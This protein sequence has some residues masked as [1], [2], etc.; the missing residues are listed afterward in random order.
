MPIRYVLVTQDEAGNIGNASVLPAEASGHVAAFLGALSTSLDKSAVLMA[1]V[2][3]LLNSVSEWPGDIT[4]N[5]LLAMQTFAGAVS[6]RLGR[7]GWERIFADM[8]EFYKGAESIPSFMSI[9]N[10]S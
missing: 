1:A 2:M 6:T 7:E 3:Q 4:L 9:I 8:Q 5:S 10:N